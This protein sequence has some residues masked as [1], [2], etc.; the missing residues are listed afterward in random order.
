MS[1]LLGFNPSF[2]TDNRHTG[3]L[4]LPKAYTQ[5][6]ERLFALVKTQVYKALREIGKDITVEALVG[7]YVRE[8]RAR[9]IMFLNMPEVT[10]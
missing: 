8:F 6:I 7:L 9:G 4:T 10:I 3:T 2:Y 5:G 1:K